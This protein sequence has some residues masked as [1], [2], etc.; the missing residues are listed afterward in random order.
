MQLF[1]AA[2]F[3]L[4]LL[5]ML[6]E[7]RMENFSASLYNSSILNELVTKKM[8]FGKYKGRVIC[9]L[10]EHY[11]VWFHQKGFPEGKLGMLMA[12]IYEIKLN[13]LEYLRRPLREK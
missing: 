6:F 2:F 8:P 11:L 3:Y 1:L 4:I 10:P 9:D 13:G 5:H 12:S 7:N